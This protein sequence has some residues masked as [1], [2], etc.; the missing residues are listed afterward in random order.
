MDGYDAMRCAVWGSVL[1]TVFG[2]G[3]AAPDTTTQ[4]SADRATVKL[5]FAQAPWDKAEELAKTWEAVH[6]IGLEPGL[7]K[8]LEANGF[9]LGQV[10]T[11]LPEP[12]GGWLARKDNRLTLGPT[13]HMPPGFRV[14]AKPPGK[15]GRRTI[16]YRDRHGVVGGRDFPNSRAA[17]AIRCVGVGPGGARLRLA[18][19]V[20][21]RRGAATNWK[22]RGPHRRAPRLTTH[23]YSDLAWDVTVAPGTWLLV[24]CDRE[25]T[26][27]VGGQ[28]MLAEKSGTRYVNLLI[29]RVGP[30]LAFPPATQPTR[31]QR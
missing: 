14:V 23:R 16:M 3:C 2:G 12:L 4:P 7:A 18:P 22:V 8:H 5:I 28:T 13:V 27:S 21:W 17:I 6:P 9:R 11:R 29:V 19:E 31:R 24:G 30:D 15:A 26:L 1:A 25:Q 20:Q 10:R